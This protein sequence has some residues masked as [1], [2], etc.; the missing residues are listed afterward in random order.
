[1]KQVH[2]P[3]NTDLSRTRMNTLKVFLNGRYIPNQTR[4]EEVYICAGNERIREGA[5]SLGSRLPWVKSVS[6]P[7]LNLSKHHLDKAFVLL[8]DDASIQFVDHEEFKR[9]NPLGVIVLLS[10][11]QFISCAP[12]YETEARYPNTKKASLI[13]YADPNCDHSAIVAAAIRCA[14]D[15][16]NIEAQSTIKRFIFLLVDDEPRWFSQ[17]LPTLYEIIGQRAAVMTART[18]EDAMHALKIYGDDI[19]C[20]I[21][22]IN[23][24]K[25]NKIGPNGVE[26]ARSTHANYPRFT[27]IIASNSENVYA[28]SDIA[29]CMR[30]GNAG[31]IVELEQY[32]RNFAGLGDFLFFRDNQIIGRASTLVEL[33][34][35]IARLALHDIDVLERYAARDYFSTWLYM[36]GFRQ[37][38]D[39][40]RP[41]SDC[42]SDLVKLLL[43][44]LDAEIKKVACEPYRFIDANGNEIATANSLQE[45]ASIMASIDI[46]VLELHSNFNAFSTWFMR[47]GYN[48]LADEL[49]PLH[50]SGED[51]RTR[52]LA[53]IFRYNATI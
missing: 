16:I 17:F 41:R 34:N 31:A 13:L 8:V 26:L 23:L 7:P 29:F 43:T 44:L 28:L 24:P 50:G 9:N 49:R 1:M 46:S 35:E 25:D 15:R 39:Q 10:T 51:L 2:A 22:D 11:D 5:A 42:G 48:E 20:L 36:H 12:P 21:T 18:Y 14:E 6:I 40:L 30:K 38:G 52:I 3:S 33:R 27:I 37:L 4:V 45:F 53:V 47:K 19:I 32:V